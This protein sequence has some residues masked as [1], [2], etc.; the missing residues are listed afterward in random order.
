MNR[1][2]ESGMDSA[3]NR[4]SFEEFVLEK[5][6]EDNLLEIEK[7]LKEGKIS[8]SNKEEIMDYLG[9]LYNKIAGIKALEY[10]Y[11]GELNINV[12]T[13]LQRIKMLLEKI[14]HA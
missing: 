10:E 2:N 7:N 14:H 6:D 8:N 4:R 12:N 1:P 5:V 9:K 11:E 13:Y 3:L